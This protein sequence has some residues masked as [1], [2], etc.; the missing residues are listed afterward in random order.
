MIV[1][2]DFYLIDSSLN[3]NCLAIF[4]TVIIRIVIPSIVLS[5]I[6]ALYVLFGRR[7]VKTLQNARAQLWPN[8]SNMNIL[9]LIVGAERSLYYRITKTN[10][11]N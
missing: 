10:A 11:V 2:S 7:N 6:S 5:I 8:V 9:L 1:F 3:V 4:A